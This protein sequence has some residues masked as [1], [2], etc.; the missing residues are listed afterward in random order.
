MSLCTCRHFCPLASALPISCP[1]GTFGAPTPPY[2]SSPACSGLCNSGFYCPTAS[3][4]ATQHACPAGR[5]GSQNGLTNAACSGQCQQGHY[6]SSTAQT[7]PAC[8]GPCLSGFYCG[9]GSISPTQHVCPAHSSS[10]VGSFTLR[11]C[12]CVPG[13]WSN[14]T[15]DVA[16]VCHLC[17]QNSTSVA[18]NTDS[19]QSCL[20]SPG[21]SA[22]SAGPGRC[23]GTSVNPRFVASLGCLAACLA[24]EY[25]DVAGGLCQGF[26]P[27]LCHVLTLSS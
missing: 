26:P 1:A 27:L 5:F 4:S 8:N 22:H 3:T 16:F 7:S 24:N 14:G 2:L 19:L 25:Q 15:L 20:C 17:P 13:F 10:P 11:N 23:L 9:S 6:G 21:F 18:G 12:S